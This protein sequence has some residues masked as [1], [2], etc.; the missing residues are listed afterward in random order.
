MTQQP[1]PSE[2]PKPTP[3]TKPPA[4]PGLWQ[5]ATTWWKSFLAEFRT[6]LPASINQKLPNDNILTGAIAAIIIFV[7]WAISSAISSPSPET[8]A[9]SSP[10][11][12]PPEVV[13]VSPEI[14]AVDDTQTPPEVAIAPEETPAEI[15]TP[16]DS[17]LSEPVPAEETIPPPPPV[18]T[19]EQTFIAAVQN[20]TA[21]L[22]QQYS[23]GLVQSIQANFPNNL[24]TVK[25]SDGW[26]DFNVQK[27]NEIAA[28]IWSQAQKF[29]L[30]KLTITDSKGNAIARNPVVGSNMIVLKRQILSDANDS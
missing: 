29:N 9:V 24:L 3:P 16:A 19:P 4:K 23:D 2:S 12:T 22:T 17:T 7:F 6:L 10:E 30:A 27:Q 5:T 28:D 21:S 11:A 13:A 25:L 20:Q 26:Y 1:Q 14:A 15:E 8:V 18:L